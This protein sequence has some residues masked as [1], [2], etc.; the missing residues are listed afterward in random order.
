M[1]ASIDYDFAYSGAPAR[2]VRMQHFDELIQFDAAT[3]VEGDLLTNVR[4]Q[5]GAKR[6]S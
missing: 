3:R 5:G 1:N 2:S 4:M 6:E